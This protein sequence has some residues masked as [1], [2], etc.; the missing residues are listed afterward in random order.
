MPRPTAQTWAHV[1]N[2]HKWVL[3][4]CAVCGPR[5]DE[6]KFV[7]FIDI[8]NLV[9]PDDSLSVHQRISEVFQYYTRE[10]KACPLPGR[11]AY[12]SIILP[13]S[14]YLKFVDPDGKM[15]CEDLK[16]ATEKEIYMCDDGLSIGLR[17]CLT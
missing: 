6:A 5:D 14:S 10:G 12:T 16:T 3:D 17:D 8:L 11:T 4:H 7:K 1:E 13:H 15:T 9:T 2:L